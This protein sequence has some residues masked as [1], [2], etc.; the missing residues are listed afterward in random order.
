[1]DMVSDRLVWCQGGLSAVVTN[2]GGRCRII[3]LMLNGVGL[4]PGRTEEGG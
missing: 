3:Y 4:A 2:G 1:M